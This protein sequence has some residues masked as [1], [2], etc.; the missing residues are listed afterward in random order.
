MPLLIAPVNKEFD[1]K[2]PLKS[3]VHCCYYINKVHVLLYPIHQL[4]CRIF[5][6]NNIKYAFHFKK[7]QK[8]FHREFFRSK[9]IADSSLKIILCDFDFLSCLNFGFLKTDY[10]MN[11][12]KT[13]HPLNFLH[14]SL[15]GNEITDGLAAA[16]TG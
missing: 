6:K 1:K 11:P 5:G 16:K 7:T 12:S 15:K 9:L 14:S 2:I 10:L 4:S 13:T 3:L 8:N